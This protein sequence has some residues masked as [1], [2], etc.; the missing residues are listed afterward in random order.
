M[1][2]EWA[3]FQQV[4]DPARWLAKRFAVKEAAS[5]A[6]GTG[7]RQGLSW[8]H[9]ELGHDALGR[10]EIYWHGV[11]QQRLAADGIKSW[12]SLSDEQDYVLATVLLER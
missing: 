11:M 12:V 8:Q 3:Q 7:F 4:K 1:P 5:K 6:L 2:G 9:I 10:P